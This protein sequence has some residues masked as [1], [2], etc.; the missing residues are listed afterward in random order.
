MAQKVNVTVQAQDGRLYNF[1]DQEVIVVLSHDGK[2]CHTAV[3]GEAGGKDFFTLFANL[4]CCGNDDL[5]DVMR[6]AMAAAV[7]RAEKLDVSPTMQEN[8]FQRIDD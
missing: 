2:N 4:L 1:S 5:A 7:I 6:G 8:I 3:V